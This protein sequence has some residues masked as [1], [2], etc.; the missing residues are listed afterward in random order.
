M[1]GVLLAGEVRAVTVNLTET[2]YCLDTV[3]WERDLGNEIR[4]QAQ[5]L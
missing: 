4:T 2:Y 5:T 3:A 1:D